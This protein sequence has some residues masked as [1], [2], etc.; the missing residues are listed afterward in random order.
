MV[1]VWLM[2][3]KSPELAGVEIICCCKIV[4][5]FG[6]LESLY[7]STL[8]VVLAYVFSLTWKKICWLVLCANGKQNLRNIFYSKSKGFLWNFYLLYSQVTLLTLMDFCFTTALHSSDLV[9]KKSKT[10]CALR[11]LIFALKELLL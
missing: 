7:I 5:G 6:M 9:R 8:K 3:L 1:L 10:S 11:L 4:F 2:V